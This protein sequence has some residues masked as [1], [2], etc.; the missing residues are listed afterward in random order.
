ME[1]M[2][3]MEDREKGKCYVTTNKIYI[4]ESTTSEKLI[5]K[6]HWMSYD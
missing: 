6:K 4:T 1:K 3:R 2:E 5:P